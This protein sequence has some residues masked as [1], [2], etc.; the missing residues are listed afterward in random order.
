MRTII[1]FKTAD[2]AV[3]GWFD[4]APVHNAAERAER[5]ILMQAGG[6][7][8]TTAG[9]S[10]RKSKKVSAP[11]EPPHSH[12]GILRKLILFAYDPFS[13]SVV[14]GAL[15]THQKFLDTAGQ[16]VA[17]TV[18]AILEDGGTIGIFEVQKYGRWRRADLRS[19]GGI[20]GYPT[21][22]RKVKIAARP[23]M[24]PALEK[25]APRFPELWRNSVRAVA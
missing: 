17:G 6:F 4:P 16:F 24:W 20:A 7:V 25:T 21:R 14:V 5:R 12:I 9:R 23:Y 1:N 8:R 13:A 22:V 2:I 18:P 3:T 15:K 10:I 11:G 19:R